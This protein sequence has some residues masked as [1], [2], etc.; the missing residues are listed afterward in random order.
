[1]HQ[2]PIKGSAVPPAASNPQ[3]QVRSTVKDR[4]LIAQRQHQLVQAAIAVFIKKGF[5][6]ASVRDIGR[7]AGLTQGTIYNYIRSKGDI[8]YLACD[9]MIRAYQDAVYRAVAEF[10]DPL[11]RLRE[12]VRATTEVIET[13]QEYILLVYRSSHE[14]DKKSRRAIVSLITAH[15]EYFQQLVANATGQQSLN[16]SN[17][18]LIANIL[19]FLPT[20]LAFRRW[21]LKRLAFD[22]GEAADLLVGFMMG[23]LAAAA[24]SKPKTKTNKTSVREE[25]HDEATR[26]YRPSAKNGGGR[27]AVSASR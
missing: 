22:R 12:A 19:T 15:I 24:A 25:R 18:R 7:A 10:D 2:A 27:S 5:H 23:G 1:M 20:M 6:K 14:L 3:R 9:E 26:V 11:D 17:R 4:G 13:H 21:D 8:L 16:H